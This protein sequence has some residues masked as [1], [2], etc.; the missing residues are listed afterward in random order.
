MSLLSSDAMVTEPPKRVVAGRKQIFTFLKPRELARMIFFLLLKRPQVGSQHPF[1]V[2]DVKKKI[3]T[4][5]SVKL[6]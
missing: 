6:H 5:L 4:R 2:L 1:D 3:D